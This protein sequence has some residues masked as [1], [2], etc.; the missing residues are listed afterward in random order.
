MSRTRSLRD[1]IG[2]EDD[3]AESDQQAPPE[4]APAA[5]T[6]KARKARAHTSKGAPAGRATPAA[7]SA[8]VAA[9]AKRVRATKA[10]PTAKAAPAAKAA[11]AAPAA[12]TTPRAPK[13]PVPETTVRMTVDLAASEHLALA[14][15][16]LDTAAEAGRPRLHAQQVA[17][18][19]LRRFLADDVLR[20]KVI[21]DIRAGRDKLR[22]TEAHDPR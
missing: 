11:T 18:V 16:C 7:K 6:A 13:P 20:R 19:L 17:R 1:V 15:L 14:R 9:L 21:A 12:K 10:E 2:V 5:T 3:P 8:G 4:L 22:A